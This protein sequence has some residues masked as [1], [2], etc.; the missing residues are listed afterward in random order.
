ML[1]N[2]I[3]S[4]INMTYGQIFQDR[5]CAANKCSA[6]TFQKKR[7][8]SPSRRCNGCSI[9]NFQTSGLSLYSRGPKNWKPDSDTRPK[10]AFTVKL[11][12]SLIQKL[13]QYSIKSG[14]SLSEV[15]SLALE[16]FLRKGRGRG[17]KKE[18]LKTDQ[19]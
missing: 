1:T 14:Y 7:Y 3:Y 10:I 18:N 12:P 17:R 16:T 8:H 19:A 11:T 2:V 13:R 5:T 9:R 15:V 6:F 4:F